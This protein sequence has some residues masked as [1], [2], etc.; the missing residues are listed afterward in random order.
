MHTFPEQFRLAHARAFYLQRIC[1]N[2][3][4]VL[5]VAKAT[6]RYKPTFFEIL[7][8]AQNVSDAHRQLTQ[9]YSKEVISLRT[10]YKWARG[11]REAA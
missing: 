11:R 2:A 6:T 7:G 1:T 10:A 4:G 9:R 3:K 8:E 5:T